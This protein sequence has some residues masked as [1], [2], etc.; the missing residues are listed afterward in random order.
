MYNISVKY[1]Y[2]YCILFTK[3]RYVHIYRYSNYSYVSFDS[4]SC[5]VI[6]FAV[7]IHHHPCITY[8]YVDMYI[9]ETCWRACEI[10]VI[11]F[12]M[13]M[14][15]VSEFWHITRAFY[16]KWIYTTSNLVF[17]FFFFKAHIIART[18]PVQKQIN[19]HDEE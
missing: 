17:F 2:E 19:N 1:S 18:K 4:C 6:P 10:S 16:S 13:L 3:S 9:S 14:P 15:D 8:V 5:S 11:C 7:Q 12:V